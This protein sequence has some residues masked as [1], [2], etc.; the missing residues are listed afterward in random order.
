[1]INSKIKTKIGF[2]LMQVI[3]LGCMFACD[4]FETDPDVKVP[5]VE[6]KGKN[7]AVLPKGSAF[8]DLSTHLTANVPVQFSITE[9]TKKGLLTDFGK[10]LLQYQPGTNFSSG[11]DQFIFSVFSENKLVV[12]D[13]VIIVVKRDSTQLPC[14]IYPL[15]DYATA[16]PNSVIRIDVL[17]NDFICSIDSSDI[18]LSIHRPDPSYPPY[19]GT[20]TIVN[21]HIVFSSPAV[22]N[23][24]DKVVYKIGSASNPSLV[25]YGIAYI[26][27]AG[28]CTPTAGN[29]SIAIDSI[30][31][32]RSWILSVFEN[33][34]LCTSVASIHQHPAKGKL[35]IL[36]Q[37]IQYQV[38]DTTNVYAGFKDTF[39]YKLCK[40]GDCS[41]AEVNIHAIDSTVM[42][43]LLAVADTIDIS[44]NTIPQ[45]GLD[46]MSNDIT[47][48]TPS[49][50]SIVE[51]PKYGTAVTTDSVIF[52][53]RD[54]T[55]PF[56]DLIVY[57]ICDASGCSE[58]SV[59]IKRE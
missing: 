53:K 21:N 49:S 52:Y 37:G 58:A 50:L 3:V 23:Q 5:E 17:A 55:K 51:H 44:G 56:D 34:T 11:S 19:V 38:H 13:T 36:P 12:T 28:V 4:T 2:A 29:D 10:G 40:N 43:T 15:N 32:K 59:Y 14:G 45:I 8:I 6:I 27:P 18:Q 54:F 7:F 47:C 30:H 35:T 25:A 20:A 39:S 41:L 42:C 48:Y 22:F 26:T 31:H 16:G 33:D 57:K 24:P 46:V 9:N 1:M